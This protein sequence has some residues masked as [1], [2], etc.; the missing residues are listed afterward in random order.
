MQLEVS[1][2]GGKDARVKFTRGL[3]AREVTLRSMRRDVPGATR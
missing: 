2:G 1:E 3:G